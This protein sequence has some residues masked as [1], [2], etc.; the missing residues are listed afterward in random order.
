MRD[1]PSGETWPR[2]RCGRAD[3][4]LCVQR[5][6]L[7]RL[8]GRKDRSHRTADGI[9][10]LLHRVVVAAV[11]QDG[12]RGRKRPE[13]RDK[14]KE[15]Q[16]RGHGGW[17]VFSVG[18]NGNNHSHSLL[19]YKVHS[20]SRI[21]PQRTLI[22]RFGPLLEALYVSFLPIYS[23]LSPE[24]VTASACWAAAR[25]GGLA[26]CRPLWRQW[27]TSCPGAASRRLRTR[28]SAGRPG[29]CTRRRRAS[30]ASAQ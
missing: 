2:P 8:R 20:G 17:K 21:S 30:P 12:G 18:S 14:Q 9:H 25:I 29:T 24:E 28:S 22:F 4:T 23:E 7:L 27:T 11:G 16:R 15:G 10:Q 26:S 6:C 19:N 1:S 13:E 3:P 5:L